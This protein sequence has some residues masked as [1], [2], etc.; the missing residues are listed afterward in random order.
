VLGVKI[1]DITITVTVVIAVIGVVVK[2]ILIKEFEFRGF[3]ITFVENP[4]Q[5]KK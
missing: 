2:L 4:K 3:K 1:M 5:L